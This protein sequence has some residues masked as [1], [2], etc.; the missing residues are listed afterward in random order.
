[1][2]F[3]RGCSAPTSSARTAARAD[4]RGHAGGGEIDEDLSHGTFTGGPA[5]A[6]ARVRLAR[7]GAG[8]RAAPFGS[9]PAHLGPRIWV[10][11]SG[12][13]PRETA[14]STRGEAGR[15]PAGGSEIARAAA[16]APPD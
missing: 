15:A 6:G 2:R 3:T 9:I 11:A 4:E 12:S 14:R 8:A 10:A 13:Y 7:G 1:M 16:A 5:G